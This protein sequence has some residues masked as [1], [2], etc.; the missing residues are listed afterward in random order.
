[1]KFHWK[2]NFQLHI[3]E[4]GLNLCNAGMV[5]EW[6]WDE[7]S[8]Y[9]VVEGT[10]FYDVQIDT[11]DN[12]ITN[13]F[14]SCPYAADGKHCKHMAAALFE[15]F[16]EDRALP[17]FDEDL[18][19][20]EFEE[21]TSGTYVDKSPTSAEEEFISYKDIR[22]ILM[23]TPKEELVELLQEF[24]EENGSVANI[25]VSRFSPVVPVGNLLVLKQEIDCIFID[26]AD[27]SGFI[28]YHEAM[29]CYCDLS[30]FLSVHTNELMKKGQILEA[31]ELSTYAFVAMGN[32]DMDDDGE[33]GML[34]DDCFGIWRTLL[35]SANDQQIAHM[36]AW[37]QQGVNDPE[38]IDYMQDYLE[39]FLEGEFW[40][41]ESVRERM[42]RL[43]ESIEAVGDSS[44]CPGTYFMS[45]GTVPN[46]SLRMECMHKL[47]YPPEEI[48][49]YEKAHWHFRVVRES[50]YNLAMQDGDY[51]RAV[52][53][54]EEGLAR[55]NPE[56]YASDYEHRLIELYHKLGEFGKE[57]DMRLQRMRSSY[58]TLADA[59]ALKQLCEPQEWKEILEELLQLT[60]SAELI[61]QLLYEEKRMEELFDYVCSV[62]KVHLCNKYFPFFRDTHSDVIL[63][64]YEELVRGLAQEAR[65]AKRYRE[66]DYYLSL[67]QTYPGGDSL[68]AKL[69]EQ[70]VDL[71]P[72]RKVM[73]QM[74]EKYLPDNRLPEQQHL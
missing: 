47:G 49:A 69:A 16:E 50:A 48:L 36:K 34:A 35:E 73:V 40:D 22:N 53:I 41:E 5:H 30:N 18:Y 63:A 54:T 33:S 52:E 42:N 19:D 56:R 1:M 43:D 32:V 17:F 72:T 64:E 3:L 59:K 44:A 11:A 70:W 74:L 60:H 58:F 10:V 61:C 37:F 71:Y 14:C 21:E 7:G 15:C 2:N 55:D 38:I 45:R 6:K 8:L 24:A 4:R 12:E 27:R 9:A 25:I 46:V 28:N 51:E 13:M 65:N 68:V 31:F 23:E 39:E 66:L 20:E 62:G 29:D 67:M 57:K 26:H